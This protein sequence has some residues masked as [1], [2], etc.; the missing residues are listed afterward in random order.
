M[1]DDSTPEIARLGEHY[2]QFGGTVSPSC[3]SSGVTEK[4]LRNEIKFLNRELADVHNEAA[5]LREKVQ[6]L[7]RIVGEK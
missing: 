5:L 2:A 3:C 6:T 1:A 4:H 7:A